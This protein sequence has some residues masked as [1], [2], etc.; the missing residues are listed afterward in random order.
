M[1]GNVLFNVATLFVAMIAVGLAVWQ[2][3]MARRQLRLNEEQ[4]ARTLQKVE[5]GQAD[6]Q[7]KLDGALTE[8]RDTAREIRSIVADLQRNTEERV[9]KVVDLQLENQQALAQAQLE[10]QRANTQTQAEK[11]RADAEQQAKIAEQLWGQI[12]GGGMGNQGSGPRAA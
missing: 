12:F 11:A 4:Q 1:D 9:N 7:R 6:M 8:I 3:T 5:D 2:G 10:A